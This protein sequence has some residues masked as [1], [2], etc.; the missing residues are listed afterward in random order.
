MSEGKATK[1]TPKSKSKAS[2]NSLK[3]GSE[4]FKV[5]DTILVRS[6]ASKPYV[7]IIRE[8][9]DKG[10]KKSELKLAW[11]Y[12][13]EE[14]MGGR[15]EFHGEKELFKS[16][17]L[18]TVSAESVARKCRVHSMK[19]YQALKVVQTDD[20]FSRFTYLPSTHA[21]RPDRV[22]VFCV[23]EMPYNPDRFMIMCDKCE[24]WHHPECQDY[25]SKAASSLKKFMCRSCNAKPEVKQE[26]PKL[27]VK[28]EA[29]VS[30]SGHTGSKKRQK[31][32]N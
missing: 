24:E 12:R 16:D 27:E 30:G 19:Q 10:P 6:S 2:T 32:S 1:S 18:D 26:K 5:G 8:I 21:F 23:C 9:T 3:I 20:F 15:K 31:T 29:P 22:P 28:E 25:D 7:G 11:F 4:V 17:H 13:P 14:A